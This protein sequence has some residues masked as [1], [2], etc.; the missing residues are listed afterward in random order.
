MQIKEK[1]KTGWQALAAD[2]LMK[3]SHQEKKS[4]IHDAGFVENTGEETILQDI[5]KQ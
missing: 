5:L 4:L 1:P 3:E 2:G